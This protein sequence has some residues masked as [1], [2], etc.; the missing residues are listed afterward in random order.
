MFSCIFSAPAIPFRMF[1]V[2]TINNSIFI[3]TVNIELK[4]ISFQAENEDQ[5]ELLC[6]YIRKQLRRAATEKFEVTREC[7]Q[8]PVALPYRFLTPCGFEIDLRLWDRGL[9]KKALPVLVSI[10][11]RETR[12]WFLHFRE[13]L[14]AELRTQ[15]MPD[16][17]IERVR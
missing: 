3:L 8:S 10:L 9:M 16:E 2:L 13:R 6:S 1:F 17:D 12:G 5:L 11:E 15:K 14:I 7:S 4:I